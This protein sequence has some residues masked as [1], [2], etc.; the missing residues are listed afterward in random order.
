MHHK[1]APQFSASTYY[2]GSIFPIICLTGIMMSMTNK[3]NN[4][5]VFLLA[6]IQNI[7]GQNPVQLDLSVPFSK[8]ERPDS[9][10][11][12]PSN[13]IDSENVILS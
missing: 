5:G 4:F 10:N 2:Y 7:T 6:D 12:S 3:F 8:G 11:T 13:Q 1:K 9:H